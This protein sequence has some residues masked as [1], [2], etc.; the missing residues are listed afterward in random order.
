MV[1]LNNKP[2][3]KNF[4]LIKVGINPAPF[5]AEV[6][7]LDDPWAITTGRQDKIKVQREAKSLAIRGIRKSAI[8]ERNRCDVHES[9]F[10]SIAC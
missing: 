7:G 10:T 4:R 1:D 9:R 8:G 5:L 2:V 3:Y 6:D